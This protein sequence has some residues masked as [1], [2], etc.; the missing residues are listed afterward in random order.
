MP[1]IAA[2]PAP[3]TPHRCSESPRLRETDSPS[4]SR[5]SEPISNTNC[6]SPA[7]GLSMPRP[8][9]RPAT[10][11]QVP[12]RRTANVRSS[13]WERMPNGVPRHLPSLPVTVTGDARGGRRP[14][15]TA[16]AAVMLTSLPL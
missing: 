7:A 13:P 9:Q 15:R 2:P 8:G 12:F 5:A 3:S 14:F 16:V 4:V 1:T 11:V 10:T 6:L